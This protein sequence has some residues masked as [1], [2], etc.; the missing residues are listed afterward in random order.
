[1]S[2]WLWSTQWIVA[3]QAIH[4]PGLDGVMSGLT[5]LGSELFY[6]L[7]MPALLWSYD[8]GLGMRTGIL[9]LGGSSL[10]GILK[11]AFRLPRPF[12]VDPAVRAPQP[13]ASFG[14]PSGHS[15][16]AVTVWGYLA[17][18]LRRPWVTAAA[19]LLILGI[20]F[21]RPYLGVHFAADVVAGWLVGGLVLVVFLQVE[22][23]AGRWLQSKGVGTRLVVVLVASFVVIGVGALVVAA[24]SGRAVPAA[25]IE[26]YL[27]AVPTSTGFIATAPD[28]LVSAAGALLGFSIGCVLLDDWG[29]FDAARGGWARLWR[30]VLG[31]VGTLALYLGLRAVSPSGEAFRYLRYAVVG[32]WIAYGAPR[33]FVAL[34]LG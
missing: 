14:L 1:M 23:P 15:Q 29:R 18:R 20:S 12:W 26:N 21:S 34:K 25:W 17:V 4:V 32:F 11:L 10:N 31:V 2:G 30:F 6:L 8:A 16:N 33:A 22:K 9:L 3:L 5:F 27:R 24:T 13:E 7:V 19:L 28:D